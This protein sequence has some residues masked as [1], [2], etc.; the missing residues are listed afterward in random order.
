M[1]ETLW[2][3]NVSKSCPTQA[4]TLQL[5]IDLFEGLCSSQAF[6]FHNVKHLG[7]YNP[8]LNEF[9]WISVDDIPK[10]VL[11]EVDQDL[12]EPLVLER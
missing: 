3:I 6:L 12:I 2:G 8:R 5:L 10:N 9:Y 11:A 4:Q 1:P 7:I